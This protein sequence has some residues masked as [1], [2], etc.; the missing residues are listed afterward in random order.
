MISKSV[1][2][3][4]LGLSGLFIVALIILFNIEPYKN[5]LKSRKYPGSKFLTNEMHLNS[6]IYKLDIDRG[7]SCVTLDDSSYISISHSRNYD[8]PISH[9]DAFLK[10]GDS[11][12][13]EINS[14]TL[15][16]IRGREEFHFIIG[17]FINEK[18]R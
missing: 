18:S 15:K 4:V 7:I 9:L 3:N 8:Y 14:D 17:E 10:I 6:K 12:S 11:L 2:F 5:I 1:I 16:V 13:K